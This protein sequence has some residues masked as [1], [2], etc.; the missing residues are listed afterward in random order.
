MAVT[1][2]KWYKGLLEPLAAI[3]RNAASARRQSYEMG[4]RPQRKLPRPVISV[5][6]LTVGGTRENA[7]DAIPLRKILRLV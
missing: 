6:N 3:Y 5:G 1:D 2:D 4:K 7:V